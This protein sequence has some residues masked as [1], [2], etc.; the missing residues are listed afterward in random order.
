M[1]R[2]S[3][4]RQTMLLI[5]VLVL[6]GAAARAQSSAAPAAGAP[7]LAE[8][9]QRVTSRPEFR[10]SHFGIEFLSLDDGSVVYTQNPDKLFVPGSTT[11]LLTE[12]TALELLGAGYRFHTRVYRTGPVAADGTLTGDLILVAS[13]DPNLSNRIRPDGT[14]AFENH[15][16][17][18]GGS[19]DTRAV[20]GDPL[21][22]IREIAKQVA[23]KGVKRIHGRVLVDISLYPEGQ[24]EGGTAV[25]I[26]PII[27]NDNVIDVTVAPGLTQGAPAEVHTSPETSYVSFVNKTTTG[28]AGSKSDFDMDDAPGSDGNTVITLTGGVP[29]GSGAILH[30]YP[31][32]QPSR[33]AETVLR[34]ALAS[35]GVTIEPPSGAAAPDFKALATSY[36]D[37]NVVAEHISLPLSEEVK[38]TLKVSQNLHASSTPYLLAAVLAHS[39]DLQAGFDLEHGFLVKA[40]LDVSGA[41]QSDG[42]G[43]Q[44]FYTPDF[45]SRYLDFMSRQ[46]DFQVFYNA[47][48]V[49]GRDGTLWNIQPDSPGAGHVRAKT[50]TFTQP[51]MLNKSLMITGKGL[52]GYLTTQDG[53]HLAFAIYVN[54]VA[55]SRDDPDAVTKIAGQALGEIAAA[56]Y[57]APAPRAP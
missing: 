53:R 26:S 16:H 29:L 8:R 35:A 14:L 37:A 40:G 13:G 50:G 52:A 33:F 30:S 25:V 38:V 3:H 2:G 24:R 22:V 11:K 47:L 15:D 43:A 36:T 48:P 18:Y 46:K 34:E 44:A 49:L 39:T 32:P 9:I 21:A 1:T 17:S 27:V 5:G 45:M 41:A 57:D 4:I 28:A 42:A 19:P 6:P 7:T 56:A 12:G 31:V 20:A 51:N 54:L 10:H 23:H 55:V